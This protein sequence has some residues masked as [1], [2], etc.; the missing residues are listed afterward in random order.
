MVGS[1]REGMFGDGCTEKFLSP[2]HQQQ[3][4]RST[5]DGRCTRPLTSFDHPALPTCWQSPSTAVYG[6]CSFLSISCF[7]TVYLA[8]GPNRKSVRGGGT[9]RRSPVAFWRLD[10]F[11]K[12]C[13]VL[14]GLDRVLQAVP[15]NLVLLGRQPPYFILFYF[16]AFLSSSSTCLVGGVPSTGYWT[17]S[18]VWPPPGP[19]PCVSLV[20]WITFVRH[21][22]AAAG[23][24]A[25][26][27]TGASS[28]LP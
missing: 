12:K 9:W 8:S 7:I 21:R 4:S 16:L 27:P 25:G 10:I 24:K 1:I 28:V 15:H 2:H 14:I 22:L 5:N 11:K 23:I 19:A 13:S 20:L 17:T 3:S 6:T 26:R 18:F